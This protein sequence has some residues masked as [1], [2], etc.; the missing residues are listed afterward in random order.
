[1]IAYDTDVHVV[2]PDVDS[3]VGCLL[4]FN[5]DFLHLI[6]TLYVTNLV[7]IRSNFLHDLPSLDPELYRH[8]L[9]LKVKVLLLKGIL[10]IVF[11][12]LFISGSL[13]SMNVDDLRSNTQYT[14]GYHDE[15][16]VIEMFW[17]VVKSFSLEYQK[18]F[19]K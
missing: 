9:F 11:F 7:A 15:H 16:Q 5:Q 4:F 12:Q 6:I 13:E 3:H 14:S 8:L 10:L 18:K 17:E 19:L 1:M 2:S